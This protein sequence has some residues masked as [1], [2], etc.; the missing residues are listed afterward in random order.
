MQKDGAQ[1][2]VS[3][4]SSPQKSLPIS[5]AW[6]LLAEMSLLLVQKV[7]YIFLFRIFFVSFK[8]CL[9][10]QGGNKIALLV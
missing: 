3:I 8:V 1:Y 4:A 6:H 9:F 2:N 5:Q 10:S 7:I